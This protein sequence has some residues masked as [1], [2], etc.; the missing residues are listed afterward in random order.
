MSVEL[1]EQDIKCADFLLSLTT[2]LSY[3]D[4]YLR[5]SLTNKVVSHTPLLGLFSFIIHN[6]YYHIRD[7]HCFSASYIITYISLIAFLAFSS[8]IAYNGTR[9]EKS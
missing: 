6:L 2:R 9:K 5:E 3:S 8:F 7:P 4:N 1:R